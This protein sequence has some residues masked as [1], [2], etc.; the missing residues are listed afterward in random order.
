MHVVPDSL[1]PSA[2]AKLPAA[3]RQQAYR[4][5]ADLLASPG[6]AG[7]VDAGSSSS[8]SSSSSS[9][10]QQHEQQQ[11]GQ[12]QQQQQRRRLALVFGREVEGLAAEEIDRCDA[13][14]SIPIGRLQ[15]APGCAGGGARVPTAPAVLGGWAD[16]HIQDSLV[17]P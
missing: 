5:I 13:T 8:S 4:S 12:Q 9:E 16:M 3:G 14:L 6:M 17:G 10:A 2:A 15:G 1:C 11:Q 7:F